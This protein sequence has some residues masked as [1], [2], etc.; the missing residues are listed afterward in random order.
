MWCSNDFCPR[1]GA[2]FRIDF[3]HRKGVDFQ[4]IS[5]REFELISDGFLA[6]KTSYFSLDFLQCKEFIRLPIFIMICWLLMTNGVD[7]YPIHHIA[8]MYNP[9][10]LGRLGWAWAWIIDLDNKKWKFQYSKKKKLTTTERL[11]SHFSPMLKL[12]CYSR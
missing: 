6:Q 2:D 1:K 7:W 4:E 10:P 9:S 5:S 3:C 12:G 11:A 8:F